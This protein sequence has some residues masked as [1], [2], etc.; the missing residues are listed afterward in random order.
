LIDARKELD[1]RTFKYGFG[2]GGAWLW[3]LKP[4]SE[5]TDAEVEAAYLYL[6][7]QAQAEFA[8]AARADFEEALHPQSL[9]P[10]GARGVEEAAAGGSTSPLQNHENFGVLSKKRGKHDSSR[11]AGAGRKPSSAYDGLS[12]AQLREI[13]L[14][15][16]GL[17]GSI[18]EESPESAGHHAGNGRSGNGKPR[19]GHDRNGLS[20]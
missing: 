10:E 19:N 17:W 14:K 20:D 15:Q 5:V 8:E 13:A 9:S 16:L 12:A 3:T 2:R 4:A 7:E 6:S 18:E 1:A 11:R